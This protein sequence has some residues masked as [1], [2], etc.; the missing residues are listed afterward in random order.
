VVD[1]A[2]ALAGY[3]I[4]L[5]PELARLPSKIRLETLAAMAAALTGAVVDLRLMDAAGRLTA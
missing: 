2:A 5:A 3:S 1:D 4:V